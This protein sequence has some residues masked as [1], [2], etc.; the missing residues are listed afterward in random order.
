MCSP[1]TAP[2]PRSGNARAMSAT[3]GAWYEPEM[4]PI[5]RSRTSRCQYSPAS[6][7]ATLARPSSTSPPESTI[8]G[9]MR[10]ASTP[11]GAFERPLLRL[12]AETAMPC[13]VY[14]RPKVSRMSGRSGLRSEFVT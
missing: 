3:A 11:M 8:R 5:A 2:R 12:N 13:C 1:I 10:S 7:S 9:P 14:E 4:I 6:E